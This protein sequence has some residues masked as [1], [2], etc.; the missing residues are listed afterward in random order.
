M[1]S[2]LKAAAMKRRRPAAKPEENARRLLRLLEQN[3][4]TSTERALRERLESAIAALKQAK[5]QS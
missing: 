2:R 1:S 4:K 5:P 3:L